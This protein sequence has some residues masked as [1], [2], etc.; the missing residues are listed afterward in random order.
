VSIANDIVSGAR[1][2]GPPIREL[3]CIGRLVERTAIDHFNLNSYTRVTERRRREIITHSCTRCHICSPSA[4]QSP[5]LSFSTK[6]S[7][8]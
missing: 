3:A 5:T 7:R 1:E 8:W 6:L 4:I 2:V